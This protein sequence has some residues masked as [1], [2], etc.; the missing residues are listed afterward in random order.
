MADT[1]A[2]LQ[3]LLSLENTLDTMDAR[4]LQQQQKQQKLDA[5]VKELPSKIRKAEIDAA[6]KEFNLL[7]SAY[8]DAVSGNYA[9]AN[10]KAKYFDPNIEIFAPQDIKKRARGLVMQRN[11]QTGVVQEVDPSALVRIKEG[12]Q[13]Q[14]AIIEHRKKQQINNSYD[15]KKNIGSRAKEISEQ[16]SVPMRDAI[17]AAQEEHQ[18]IFG[19]KAPGATGRGATPENS[20][21][22]P[23][24]ARN[25]TAQAVEGQ[26]KAD[27]ELNLA[28]RTGFSTLDMAPPQKAA[29]MGKM[30]VKSRE[31]LRNTR[32]GNE[33]LGSQVIPAIYDYKDN[34]AIA[35]RLGGQNF[36]SMRVNEFLS[37]IGANDE[38]GKFLHALLGQNLF[39]EIK[40]LSGVQYS[41][42]QLDAMRPLLPGANDTLGVAMAKISGIMARGSMDAINEL[43]LME[44]EGTDT[45][46]LEHL[47]VGRD[48]GLEEKDYEVAAESL[49]RSLP[50]Q[51][52]E[53][54]DVMRYFTDVGSPV[55]RNA[56]S[57]HLSRIKSPTVN[58][59]RNRMKR[60]LGN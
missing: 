56:I 33:F 7:S 36:L 49:L 23:V 39:A 54:D 19:S 52:V 27:A 15:A 43:K 41:D 6:E 2:K 44:A 29:K 18:F 34:P 9:A 1:L 30:T 4:K 45:G 12:I 48:F 13:T 16:F 40:K 58:S 38:Q 60:A 55:F 8:V 17:L 11:I 53:R 37:T 46:R 42:K 3:Q 14:A 10:A 51:F 47:F 50:K 20:I 31:I 26:V 59:T 57:D 5:Y 24:P 35:N 28:L 21:Y 22:N 25:M 32:A